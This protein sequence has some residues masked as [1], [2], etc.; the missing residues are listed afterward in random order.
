MKGNKYLGLMDRWGFI[1]DLSLEDAIKRIDPIDLESLLKEWSALQE[2]SLRTDDT[3]TI[4]SEIPMVPV[5]SIADIDPDLIANIALYS[6]KQI[7]PDPIDIALYKTGGPLENK[8]GFLFYLK[9]GMEAIEKIRPLLREN[10]VEIVSYQSI[11]SQFSSELE[12][13]LVKDWIDSRSIEYLSNKTKYKLYFDNNVLAFRVGDANIMPFERFADI[14]GEV[15][16]ETDEAIVVS[17]RVPSDLKD[18]DPQRIERWVDNMRNITANRIAKRINQR[19]LV[20][21]LFSGSIA[22]NEFVSYEF[23]NRKCSNSVSHSMLGSIHK[24]PILGKINLEKFI[25]FRSDELPS[26]ISFREEWNMGRGLFKEKLSSETWINNVNRDL[27]EC[28]LEMEKSKQK[29]VDN[30]IEGFAWA[31][32]GVVAGVLSGTL[33]NPAIIGVTPLLLRDIKN[34][35]FAYDE[36]KKSFSSS[37]PFFFV[38]CHRQENK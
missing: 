30:V 34:A 5:A 21:E 22:S 15:I 23:I 3:C 36:M 26:F 19:L 37:S 16:D 8:A 12:D 31:G 11:S 2:T 20:A 29:I 18:I 17:T 6:D 38:E 27:D 9:E 28:K 10:L 25:E 32:L 7:I 14:G 13:Q 35:A 4:S 1:E 24:V 33:L